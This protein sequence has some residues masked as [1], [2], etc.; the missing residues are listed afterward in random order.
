MFHSSD[1]SLILRPILSLEDH[2]P[3][4][5]F[6]VEK[7]E[8]GLVAVRAVGSYSLFGLVKTE[9]TRLFDFIFVNSCSEK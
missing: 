5:C 9:L 6:V 7:W 8:V 3:V 2:L 1:C 4:C